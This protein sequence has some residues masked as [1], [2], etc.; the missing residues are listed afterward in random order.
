MLGVAGPKSAGG[1]IFWGE[2]SADALPPG[3]TLTLTL[4]PSITLT[5]ARADH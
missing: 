1:A 4:T 2:G 5:K 3:L